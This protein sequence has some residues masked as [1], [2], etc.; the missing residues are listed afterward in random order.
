MT[1]EE[2]LA[3]AKKELEAYERKVK[4]GKAFF[5]KYAEFWKIV[6]ESI[7]KQI[8]NKPTYEDVGNIYGAYKRTCPA[9]GDVALISPGAREWER[10]CRYCGQRFEEDDE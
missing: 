8:K 5:A 3:H 6:V 2:A 10:Y 9:C 4:D 7:W 1:Y